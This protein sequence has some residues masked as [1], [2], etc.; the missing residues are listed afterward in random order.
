MSFGRWRGWS[1]MG[2]EPGKSRSRAL[3]A[4]KHFQRQQKA[5]Q[6]FQ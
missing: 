3:V 2:K 6:I 5:K 1:G 4:R